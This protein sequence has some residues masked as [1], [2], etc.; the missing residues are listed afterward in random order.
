MKIPVRGGTK[1][2]PWMHVPLRSMASATRKQ[3][4][5]SLFGPRPFLYQQHPKTI[6]KHLQTHIRS[7]KRNI[8]YCR[9]YALLRDFAT[10]TSP[11][12]KREACVP[13]AHFYSKISLLRPRFDHLLYEVFSRYVLNQPLEE[14]NLWKYIIQFTLTTLE[15]NMASLAYR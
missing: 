10:M 2:C 12:I 6:I 5:R 9:L 3:I 8:T 4:Q 13:S 1:D 14:L 7:Q 11:Q 15:T